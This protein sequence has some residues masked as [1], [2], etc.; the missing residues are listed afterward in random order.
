[1]QRHSG[2]KNSLSIFLGNSDDR[3]VRVENICGESYKVVSVE[4]GCKLF[5][6]T[7]PSYS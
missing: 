6:F 2:Q 5:G 3:P 7:E 1:M 4:M